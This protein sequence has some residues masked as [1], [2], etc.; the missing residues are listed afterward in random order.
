MRGGKCDV[1][2]RPEILHDL[3]LAISSARISPDEIG[4]GLLDETDSKAFRT[5]CIVP[6]RFTLRTITFRLPDHVPR[7]SE[8]W[9]P[10]LG[11]AY[12]AR[13]SAF[14]HSGPMNPGHWPGVL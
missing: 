14:I 3:N 11:P 2:A 8:P 10:G 6:R 12:D 4:L 13:F 9:D 7:F 1:A 5:S